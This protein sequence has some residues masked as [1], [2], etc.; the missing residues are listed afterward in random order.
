MYDQWMLPASC[1]LQYFGALI[2]CPHFCPSDSL[3]VGFIDG[4]LEVKHN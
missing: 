2:A 3:R 4:V 1:V